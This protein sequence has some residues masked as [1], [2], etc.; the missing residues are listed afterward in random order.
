MRCHPQRADHPIS[1]PP[2][3]LLDDDEELLLSPPLLLDDDELLLSSPPLELLLPESDPPE[4]PPVVPS[5]GRRQ[6]PC[7]LQVASASQQ[8]ESSAH[9]YAAASL[10]THSSRHK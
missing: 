7:A 4:L 5:N 1:P 6:K 9:Q 3:E 2:P 8:L 10:G